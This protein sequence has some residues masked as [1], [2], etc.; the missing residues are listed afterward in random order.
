[1]A[2]YYAQRRC[3]IC[4]DRVAVKKGM[5]WETFK[6]YRKLDFEIPDSQLYGERAIVCKECYDKLVDEL[7]KKMLEG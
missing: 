5:L 4:G 2:E 3:D 1:M 6:S 7:R